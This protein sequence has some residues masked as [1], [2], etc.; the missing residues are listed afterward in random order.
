MHASTDLLK[1]ATTHGF[2]ITHKSYDDT[3]V[4][5]LSR[6]CGRKE[7]SEKDRMITLLKTLLPPG[8][9][10]PWTSQFPPHSGRFLNPAHNPSLSPHLMLKI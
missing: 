6:I 9:L 5:G 2:M 10:G 3:R 1:S 7:V 8:G 4:Y